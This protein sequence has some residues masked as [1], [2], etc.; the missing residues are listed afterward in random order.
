MDV[1]TA[2]VVQGDG[3]EVVRRGDV[4]VFIN[5]SDSSI[6]WHTLAHGNKAELKRDMRGEVTLVHEK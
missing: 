1:C 4:H 5:A 3:L 6:T 2:L